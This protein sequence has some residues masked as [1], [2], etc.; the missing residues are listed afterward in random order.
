[1]KKIFNIIWKD[2]ILRFSSRS[3]M[4]FF[5]IL[6]IVFTF[7]LAG[8]TGFQGGD[9]RIRLLVADQAQSSLSVQVITELGKSETVRPDLLALDKA[10]S[11]FSARNAAA[12]LVIP[13]DCDRQNSPHR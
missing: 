6:P 11:E 9:N 8:G 7:I 5:L 10:E 2:T 12:L 4:L 1:M 13:A 3:E